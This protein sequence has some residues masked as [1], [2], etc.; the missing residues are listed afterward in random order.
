M[1][2]GGQAQKRTWQKFIQQYPGSSGQIS[3]SF[4][5]KQE[6]HHRITGESEVLSGRWQ[7]DGTGLELSLCH[8]HLGDLTKKIISLCLIFS[9]VSR[10]GHRDVIWIKWNK[11]SQ[12]VQAC[13]LYWGQKDGI[14]IRFTL[15]STEDLRRALS[16]FN[17]Q[18]SSSILQTLIY[19]QLR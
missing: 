6:K 13:P 8:M 1:H 5:N 16:K 14:N 12:F 9:I 7:I 3:L 18:I 11:V 15:I 2:T 4:Y 17:F 19:E 10:D